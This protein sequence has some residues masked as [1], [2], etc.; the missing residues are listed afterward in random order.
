MIDPTTAAITTTNTTTT[1]NSPTSPTSPPPPEDD[2]VSPEYYPRLIDM[3]K[4]PYAHRGL[5]LQLPATRLLNQIRDSSQNTSI[6]YHDPYLPWPPLWS[7][8]LQNLD[9][10]RQEL[11]STTTE[12]NIHLY[13]SLEDLLLHCEQLKLK[14][15]VSY[16]STIPNLAISQ[17]YPLR[18]YWWSADTAAAW[19]LPWADATTQ[20]V[21]SDRKVMDVLAMIPMLVQNLKLPSNDEQAKALDGYFK[22]TKPSV[23]ATVN[24]LK[25]W[26]WF[27]F[28]NSNSSSSSSASSSTPLCSQCG[29]P[30]SSC[31]D[32]IQCA[33][34]TQATKNAKKN[35]LA[36]SIAKQRNLIK[37]DEQVL[38]DATT[39]DFASDLSRDQQSTITNAY[40]V[41]NLNEN[42][43][44]LSMVCD[45]ALADIGVGMCIKILP[46]DRS[47]A[48]IR[49]TIGNVVTWHHKKKPLPHWLCMLFEWSWQRS[50][51]QQ[52][53]ATFTFHLEGRVYE[54]I[55]VPASKSK[56]NSDVMGMG[57]D[58]STLGGKKYFYGDLFPATAPKGA[59]NYMVDRDDEGR[60]RDAKYDDEKI[61][62]VERM[63]RV[64]RIVLEKNV[65]LS[66]TNAPFELYEYPVLD[67]LNPLPPNDTLPKNPTRVIPTVVIHDTKLQIA[68]SSSASSSSPVI[69]SYINKTSTLWIPVSHRSMTSMAIRGLLTYPLSNAINGFYRVWNFERLCRYILSIRSLITRGIDPHPMTGFHGSSIECIGQVA[70]SVHGGGGFRP[71]YNNDSRSRFG[72]GT[73]VG[74]DPVRCT[75]NAGSIASLPLAQLR[76]YWDSV[77]SAGQFLLREHANRFHSI[78]PLLENPGKGGITGLPGLPKVIVG[79]IFE[80]VMN[81]P[82]QYMLNIIQT[83]CGN[84][85]FPAGIKHLLESVAV[86]AN[87]SQ[88]SDPTIVELVAHLSLMT[89]RGHIS[90]GLTAPFD[91]FD[92]YYPTAGT[93]YIKPDRDTLQNRK[94]GCGVLAVC[95]FLM[96]K[97]ELGSSNTVHTS[98]LDNRKDLKC[99]T[100]VDDTS[101]D[102][103]TLAVIPHRSE[104]HIMLTF[105]M[106]FD[107][108]I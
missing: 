76:Q 42:E 24:K 79:L 8:E 102:R 107:A 30:Q 13:V 81:N 65:E 4:G 67:T 10:Y 89:T 77:A 38:L 27:P 95:D 19:T 16:Q 39:V 94:Y 31:T 33:I 105:C 87:S 63:T 44:P 101:A 58:V 103:T 47:D 50:Q 46:N 54:G 17:Q 68:S 108:R 35:S 12:D 7:N 71:E 82:A 56:N 6:A 52:R 22:T 25:D 74:L 61:R 104:D 100:F 2:Y 26:G 93:Y 15:L 72:K 85:I 60:T 14:S 84:S 18:F 20:Q 28:S 66:W 23:I 106:M 91:T 29:Q 80:Y 59:M 40:R 86:P 98:H 5:G 78:A 64:E 75:E 55:I 51:E 45:K 70:A 34:A 49:F 99:T 92:N 1:N 11:A 21:V 90:A 57:V 36:F 69:S 83:K 73:Y 96:G 62:M 53:V 88:A 32:T 37:I 41:L 97:A 9:K 43:R 3:P 48:T